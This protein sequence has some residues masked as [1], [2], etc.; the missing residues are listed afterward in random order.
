MSHIF[1]I[2]FG[3][4]NLSLISMCPGMVI[5][6]ELTLYSDILLG[7]PPCKGQ[8]RCSLILGDQFRCKLG[9]RTSTFSIFLP[10][11]I[12][13]KNA[14]LDPNGT[15]KREDQISH[16][17]FEGAIADVLLSGLSKIKQIKIWQHL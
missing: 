6:F 17:I 1:I 11:V 14:I 13:N 10:C 9:N 5:E 8:P 4:R 3:L 7:Y 2:G 16:H 12:S 15:R